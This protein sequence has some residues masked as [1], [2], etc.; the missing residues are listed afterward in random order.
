M[1]Y[2]YNYGHATSLNILLLNRYEQLITF[3]FD[4]KCSMQILNLY[5]F[6]T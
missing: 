6:E 5:N 4:G 1:I 2:N 3:I